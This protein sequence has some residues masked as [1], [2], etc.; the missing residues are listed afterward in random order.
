[1]RIYFL[2]SQTSVLSI[3]K[4]SF[5]EDLMGEVKAQKFILLFLLF[6]ISWPLDPVP[7]PATPKFKSWYGFSFSE[8]EEAQVVYLKDR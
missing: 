1:M 5:P 3:L 6:S 8:K 4:F 7:L 2:L